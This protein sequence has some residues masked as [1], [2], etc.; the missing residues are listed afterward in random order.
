M[1][2]PNTD[3]GL[4]VE[5]KLSKKTPSAP[6]ELADY[7]YQLVW[8]ARPKISGKKNYQLFYAEKETPLNSDSE[9]LRKQF[10]ATAKQLFKEQNKGF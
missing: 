9:T 7:S 6:T 2:A 8:C 1:S 4:M 3:G 5:I 10:T